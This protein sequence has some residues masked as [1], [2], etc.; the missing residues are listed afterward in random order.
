MVNT[1]VLFLKEPGKST[2][3]EIKNG[4]TAKTQKLLIPGTQ[5]SLKTKNKSYYLLFD[6]E[7]VSQIEDESLIQKIGYAL[8]KSFEIKF[9]VVKRNKLTLEILIRCN[10][11][12]FLSTGQTSIK[13]FTKHEEALEEALVRDGD[14]T[15]QSE[16]D[17]TLTDGDESLGEVSHDGKDL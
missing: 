10:R 8:E 5:L 13:P 12:I 3:V 4:A 14:L 6:N 16:D 2:T 9:Y 15:E 7:V 17:S 11:T 1:A